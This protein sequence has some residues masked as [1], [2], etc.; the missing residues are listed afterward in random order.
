MFGFGCECPEDNTSFACGQAP[1]VCPVAG[2]L[3]P[4]AVV[5]PQCCYL[6]FLFSVVLSKAPPIF[7][8]V[9]M[10]EQCLTVRVHTRGSRNLLKL[11][12]AT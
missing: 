7:S 11:A 5:H 12:W 4:L 3:G 1:V 6:C 8:L 10:E 9:K 2:L